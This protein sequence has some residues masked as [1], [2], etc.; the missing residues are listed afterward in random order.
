MLR[1]SGGNL[2][3]AMAAL[4]PPVEFLDALGRDPGVAQPCTDAQ[5]HEVALHALPQRVDRGQ[6][7]V[8]VVVVREDLTLPR[9]HVQQE[10]GNFKGTEK[11]D[12]RR[13]AAQ[14]A[15]HRGI[16]G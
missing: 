14:E 10:V 12:E 11:R 15:V 13:Q 16:Q 9:F 4:L 7:Q 8:I 5:R 6:V 1:R 2:H 3:L